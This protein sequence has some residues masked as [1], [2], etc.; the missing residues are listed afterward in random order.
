MRKLRKNLYGCAPAHTIFLGPGR[1]EFHPKKPRPG[2]EHYIFE[3][4]RASLA[5][6]ANPEAIDQGVVGN[7]MAARFNRQGHLNALLPAVHESLLHKPCARVEGACGSGGVAVETAAHAILADLA[8]A[9]LVIG[10]EVQNTVK[11]MYGADILAGAGHYSRERK[12]GH[13]FFF[14][15]CFS[16]RAG[17]YYAKYGREDTRRGM[18]EWYALA[19]ENARRNPN[20][21]EHHNADPDPRAT[22]LSEPNP[23]AFLEHLTV[24]DCSKVTDGAS[25]LIVASEEGLAKLGVPREKAARFVGLAHCEGDLTKDPADL[26]WQDTTAAAAKGAMEMAGIRSGQLGMV[27]IHDCFTISGMLSVEAIG[28]AAPGKS[29]AFLLDGKSRLDSECPI[30]PTGGLVGFGHPTGGTGVR[31]VADLVLQLTG[32]AADCQVK[33]TDKK[34]YAMSLNMGGND[35][36]VVSFVMTAT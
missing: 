6:V 28:L 31:Q 10:V 33:F 15:N 3:A 17:A 20:A 9:V 32:Q 26:T 23:K 18:A 24:F 21:Q 13:A 2:I 35:K 27:E 4:G 36:T 8:D 7:F 14:P 1:K 12:N 34:P 19:V 25:A 11:S 30:N 16:E 29:P 22:G 5:Q